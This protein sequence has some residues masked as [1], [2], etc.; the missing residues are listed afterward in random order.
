MTVHDI[1]SQAQS[2]SAQ[3]RALKRDLGADP[4]AEALD[5]YLDILDR[6][7]QQT[8]PPMVAKPAAK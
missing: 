4:A 5:G 3:A 8:T 1:R 2:V 6:F 7:L